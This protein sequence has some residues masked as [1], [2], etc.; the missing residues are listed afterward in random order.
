MGHLLWRTA[1]CRVFIRKSR[2]VWPAAG[3]RLVVSH[4]PVDA[5]APAIP[6]SPSP[7]EPPLSRLVWSSCSQVPDL[8]C[9]RGVDEDCCRKALSSHVTCGVEGG[10]VVSGRDIQ[11]SLPPEEMGIRRC[12]CHPGQCSPPPAPGLN[13]YVTSYI[14]PGVIN[15]L[16]VRVMLKVRFW[17]GM[18]VWLWVQSPVGSCA[19]KASL[20]YMVSYRP[21]RARETLSPKRNR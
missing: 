19:F 17:L 6:S 2:G 1:L 21:V 8:R 7:E 9:C 14:K 13:K 15:G 3:T 10:P 20:F 12:E 5:S 11:L 18:V 16:N 4:S